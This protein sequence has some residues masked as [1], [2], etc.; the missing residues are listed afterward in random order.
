MPVPSKLRRFSLL[1]LILIVTLSAAMFAFMLPFKPHIKFSEPKRI[2]AVHIRTTL[3]NAGDSPIWYQG[4]PGRIRSFAFILS[5]ASGATVRRA[6]LWESGQWCRLAPGDSVETVVVDTV[7]AT[8][9][10]VEVTLGDWRG[11]NR[12]VSSKRSLIQPVSGGG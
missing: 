6:K 10:S 12:R 11:R 9:S 7:N 4:E 3:T 5:S 2:D 8:Q 1:S